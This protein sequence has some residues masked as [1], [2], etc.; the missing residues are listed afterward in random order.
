MSENDILSFFEP[1]SWSTGHISLKDAGFLFEMVRE[2]DP[3]EIIEIGVA[4]GCSSAVLLRALDSLGGERRL[5][6][7]D[8][9]DC[10][11][12]ATERA[13]GD[14]VAELAPDYSRNWRLHTGEGATHAAQRLA[15]RSIP[16]VFI[17]ADHRH[18]YPTLDLLGVLPAVSENAWVILH[19]IALEE[20]WQVFGPKYLYSGWTGEKRTPYA[21]CNIGAI[22]LNGRQKETRNKCEQ[23]LSVPWQTTI[24]NTLLSS[25]G[26]ATNLNKSDDTFSRVLTQRLEEVRYAKR[27]IMIWGAGSAGRTCL[28]SLIARK[29]SPVGFIDSDQTKVG[30]EIEGRPIHGVQVLHQDASK[31]F[32]VIA[33]MYARDI[34][35]T[36][37]VLDFS[38]GSDFEKYQTS[39]TICFGHKADKKAPLACPEKPLLGMTTKEEQDYLSHYA[40]EQF[41]GRGAIVD[42]GCWLGSTTIS[43]AAGLE[44]NPNA[45]M[46]TVHAFDTFRW[47]SWMEPYAGELSGKL[48]SGDSFLYEFQKRTS[49]HSAHITVHTGD[50]TR[51][52]WDKG[53]IE[54]LLIDA[55]KDWK[56]TSAI[57]KNFLTAVIP[58]KGLVMHQDF[59]FWGCPWIH[60]VM[61]RLRRNFVLERD[62][63]S[64]PGTVFKL[65]SPLTGNQVENELSAMD[66]SVSEIEAAYEYWSGCLRG[67]QIFLLDCARALALCGA[68]AKKKAMDKLHQLV[69]EGVHLPKLFLNAMARHVSQADLKALSTPWRELV[70]GALATQRPVWF[71]GAGSAGRSILRQNGTLRK[72]AKGM[73]DRD[74]AK[75]GK[76]VEGLLVAGIEWLAGAADPRPFVV[77]TTQFSTEVAQQL[78]TWGYLPHKDFCIAEL[79]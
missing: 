66:F 72:K 37:L 48:H 67:S 75:H 65:V 42:L 28:Q 12:F 51:L 11:Y 58:E 68:G 70:Y 26:V 43:L 55:M 44:R 29:Y 54:F 14:A 31:P 61:Y 64:S 59:K 57:N 78:C 69:K 49:P 53:P 30:S 2:I 18:P 74:P 56:L 46:H 4:S 25:L 36:L 1:P 76:L 41:S 32:I 62:L 27:P 17:D 6:S 15:G 79:V 52:P 71:W 63:E 21:G 8:I 40:R 45:S 13:V 39:S 23:I 20:K 19:D 47:H 24:E 10:C 77:V 7:F 33:S 73:V 5:H 22:R 9:A 60:L 34:E 16:L 50:L 35:K 38:A 3:L